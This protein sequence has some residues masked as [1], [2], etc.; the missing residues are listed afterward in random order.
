MDLKIARFLLVVLFFS[1]VPLAVHKI[2][3]QTESSDNSKLPSDAELHKAG[4]TDKQIEN[5]KLV[6]NE[7]WARTASE[8]AMEGTKQV[9]FTTFGQPV[10]PGATKKKWIGIGLVCRANKTIAEI[11]TGPVRNGNVRLKFDNDPVIAQ[12]W[13][14]DSDTIYSPQ[15][16]ALFHQILNAKTF[17]VEFFAPGGDSQVYVFKVLDLKEQVAKEPMCHL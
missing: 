5:L 12:N 17:K 14:H 3:A 10:T 13:T 15:P 2:A 7:I 16:K 6:H 4:F 9:T 11:Q 1:T 8:T